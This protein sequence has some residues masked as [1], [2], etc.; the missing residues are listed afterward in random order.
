MLILKKKLKKM[1]KIL[2]LT[3]FVL[4]TNSISSQI[5]SIQEAILA[6][7]E[8]KSILIAKG[9]SIL[10]DKF[11]EAKI[12]EVKKIKDYLVNEVENDD[13]LA[14]YPA[15]HW[16]ILYWTEEYEKL[17]E[18]IGNYDSI[19]IVKIRDK[20]KPQ[21]DYL[22]LKI[23]N[24]SIDSLLVLES[25]IE[26]ANLNKLNKDF[27]RV[28]LIG[29]ISKS[30]Y[31]TINQ[32]YLNKI[33]DDFLAEHPNSKYE[34]FVRTYIRHKKIPSKW[35]FGYEFFSG[36]GV[37]TDDL[38]NNFNNNVPI[39][40]AFDVSYKNIN[41]YLRNYIGFSKTKIDIP[42]D[43]EKWEKD[44]QTRIF[45]PEISLG[46]TTLDNNSFKL[47]P[48]AGISWTGI[49]ATQYDIDIH[50]SL[51]NVE[52]WATTYTTGLNFDYKFKTNKNQF[53]NSYWF[54]KLRYA[55]NL[56]Q[57]EN[58]YDVYGGNMHYITIG[59]GQFGRMM[60]DDF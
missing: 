51:R 32:E 34:K 56:P 49:T 19:Q 48:F 21:Y 4:F 39:G 16:T 57:F 58:K 41:L 11:V 37:F 60:K 18:S 17:L 31:S 12:G 6:H 44:S 55:Y 30:E 15:E 59:V 8:T 20:I 22:S 5:D 46:Y 52:K 1:K 35:G 3:L 29:L 42:Y 40:V 36:Y 28:N 13:Y 50:E 53:E 38:E 45:L 26:N 7:E 10:L 43:N 54:I 2:L 47:V 9:R 27:L 24:K 33:S 25:N 23:K 14:L